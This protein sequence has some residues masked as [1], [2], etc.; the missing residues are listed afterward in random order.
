MFMSIKRS[1]LLNALS[2]SGCFLFLSVFQFF[3]TQ[4]DEFPMSVL[5]WLMLA[6]AVVAFIITYH[7][8]PEY[9]IQEV[10]NGLIVTG[11]KTVFY[12]PD[13]VEFDK[14][15]GVEIKKN[16]VVITVDNSG[17]V[18]HP[19]PVEIYVPK[20]FRTDLITELNKKALA[21]AK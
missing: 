15:T 11:A 8:T 21:N 12:D 6:I 19:S 5:P 4:N 14:I 1:K 17:S 16:R 9:Y 13:F 20:K 2:V 3:S 18:L 7:K 10:P